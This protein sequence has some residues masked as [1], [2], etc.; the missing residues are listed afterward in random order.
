MNE[1]VVSCCYCRC[2][3]SRRRWRCAA[4]TATR[5]RCICWSRAAFGPRRSSKRRRQRPPN[6]RR[7]AMNHEKTNTKKK[8]DMIRPAIAIH[9]PKILL[10][11][12]NWYQLFMVM[13]EWYLMFICFFKSYFSPAGIVSYSF[14]WCPVILAQ[15]SPWLVQGC[16]KGFVKNVLHNALCVSIA[17][18][19][20][21][22]HVW[23]LQIKVKS[24]M[25]V[26]AWFALT[27]ISICREL[28]FKITLGILWKLHVSNSSNS[29]DETIS[30]VETWTTLKYS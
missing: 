23:Y 2:F 13:N 18:K 6:C 11:L 19:H 10:K 5:L 21:C 16:V 9:T 17:H 27:G 8:N 3:V 1:H 15:A 24:W 30:W 20:M 7:T 28:W 25:Q 4:S 12:V 29:I 22:D 14:S 26:L